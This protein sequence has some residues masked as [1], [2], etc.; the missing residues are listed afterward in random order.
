[1]LPVVAGARHTRRQIMLYT[2]VLLPVSLLPWAL[3]CAGP[4]YGLAALV[5][6]LGFIVSAWRVLRDAQDATGVSLTRDAPAKAAFR[7]SL[8]YLFVLFL[9]VAVDHFIV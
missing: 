8:L 5:L 9:A 1:M 4:I 2:L 7:Y 6:G 3:G